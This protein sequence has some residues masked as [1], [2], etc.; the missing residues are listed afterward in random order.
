MQGELGWLLVAALFAL[1]WPFCGGSLAFH[2]PRAECWH[3]QARCSRGW[4]CFSLVEVIK[5]CS[6]GWNKNVSLP[7]QLCVGG[8]SAELGICVGM[9][10]A[11]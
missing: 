6:T 1:S 11:V 4:Q 10:L 8:H 3:L 7:A 9:A 2:A 5:M